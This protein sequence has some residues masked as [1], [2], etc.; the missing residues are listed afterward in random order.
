MRSRLIR[1]ARRH[2]RIGVR[3]GHGRRYRAADQ[4]RIFKEFR[5]ARGDIGRITEGTGLGPSL[6]KRFV[7]LQGGTIRVESEPGHGAR[8]GFV[9]PQPA[10]AAA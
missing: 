4:T 10:V 6:A 1:R 5:Q 3:D 2:G 9:L 7:E 8:F